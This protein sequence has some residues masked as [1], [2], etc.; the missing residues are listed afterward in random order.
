MKQEDQVIHIQKT[1][2]GNVC[3]RRIRLFSQLPDDLWKKILGFVRQ[4]ST[5]VFDNI[6]FVRV[7]RA[8][9]QPPG[10]CHASKM[11]TL[12]LLRKYKECLSRDTLMIGKSLA[13]RMLEHSPRTYAHSFKTTQLINATIESLCG[14]L[15]C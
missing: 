9:W 10:A 5:N 2:R 7:I 1:W 12:F 3:R 15:D 8:Y 14:A 4:D 6:I 13:V 11:K